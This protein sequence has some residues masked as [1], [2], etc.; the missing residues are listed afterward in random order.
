MILSLIIGTIGG[1]IVGFFYCYYFS[2]RKRKNT[3][4]E[5]LLLHELY[6]FKQY[7]I[8]A[9]ESEHDKE[10]VKDVLDDFILGL[11]KNFGNN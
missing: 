2:S 11:M 6:Y 10:L 7:W 4:T 3:F 1:I 9:L 5:D 8:D